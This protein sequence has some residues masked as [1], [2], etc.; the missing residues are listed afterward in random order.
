MK[1][2]KEPVYFCSDMALQTCLSTIVCGLRKNRGL[3][4]NPNSILFVQVVMTSKVV[5]V[6]F[7]ANSLLNFISFQQVPYDIMSL[8]DN[9]WVC[10]K[11]KEGLSNKYEMEN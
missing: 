9:T 10:K 7:N 11:N 8:M 3:S 2:H 6:F 5:R 4:R 1:G